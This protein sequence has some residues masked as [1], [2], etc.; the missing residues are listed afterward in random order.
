MPHLIIEYTANLEA[1]MEIADLMHVLHQTAVQ[2]EEL[3]TGGLRTRAARRDQFLIADAHPDNSFINVTL[4]IASGR[5][6]TTKKSI[7]EALYRALQNF[8]EPHYESHAMALSF[9]IQE[10]DPVTR[11]KKG[12]IRQ[13]MSKR[14][15]E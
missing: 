13:Y 3:P 10:I 14:A 15:A 7:G 6:V 9:E 1:N 2:I 5:D 8:V 11:W 4:R 12:N